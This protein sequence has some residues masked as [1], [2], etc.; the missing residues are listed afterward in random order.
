M[1][2]YCAYLIDE[3]VTVLQL[4]EKETETSGDETIQEALPV[5]SVGC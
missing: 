4:A 2:F 5:E 3:Y 1:L